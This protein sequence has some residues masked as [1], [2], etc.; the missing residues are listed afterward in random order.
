MAWTT[1]DLIEKTRKDLGLRLV[2]RYSRDD[3]AETV[4]ETVTVTG[5][6]NVPA[7][8]AAGLARLNALLTAE[9]ALSLGA[10]TLPGPPKPPDPPPD[11][12]QDE[13]D[14]QAFLAAYQAYRAM[15]RAVKDGITAADAAEV[16]QAT[17]AMKNAFKPGYESLIPAL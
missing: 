3:S 16:V 12:T 7:M 5:A 11:P 8:A 15:Q 1:A 17:T 10:I 4:T 2:I 13:L 14:R 6:P 9:Q